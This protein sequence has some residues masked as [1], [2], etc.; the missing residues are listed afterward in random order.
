MI[1]TD[2]ESLHQYVPRPCANP[3]FLVSYT[4]PNTCCESPFNANAE[5]IEG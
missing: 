1:P 4:L 3:V 2:I 5:G